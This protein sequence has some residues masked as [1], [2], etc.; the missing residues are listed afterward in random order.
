MLD[1]LGRAS[2]EEFDAE[3]FA[4]LLQAALTKRHRE[5]HRSLVRVMGTAPATVARVEPVDDLGK[6]AR[7][8]NCLDRDGGEVVYVD[9]WAAARLGGFG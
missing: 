6:V 8:L 5:A 9:R 3:E 1:H 4:E 7:A 2:S